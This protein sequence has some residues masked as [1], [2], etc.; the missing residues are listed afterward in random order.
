MGQRALEVAGTSLLQ[1]P[2]IATTTRLP[3]LTVSPVQTCCPRGQ[4]TALLSLRHS[5]RGSARSS[6]KGNILNMDPYIWIY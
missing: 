6:L 1:T 2:K 4:H 3:I 5:Y